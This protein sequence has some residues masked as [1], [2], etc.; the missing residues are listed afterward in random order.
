MDPATRLGRG[1][2]DPGGRAAS[3]AATAA[4]SDPQTTPRTLTRWRPR[5]GEPRPAP[6][7]PAQSVKATGIGKVPSDGAVQVR[8]PG[9]KLTGWAVAWSVTSSATA[10]TTAATIRP[11]TRSSA[12]TLTAGP[13][14]WVGSCRTDFSVEPEHPGDRRQRGAARRALADRARRRIALTSPRIPCATFR[15][16][17]GE[18]GWLELL[19]PTPDLARTGRSSCRARSGPATR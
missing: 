7:E 3:T 6:A 12:K 14:A 16:W 18:K 11:C 4:H 10:S 8:D 15:G 9:P 2:A 17:V 1:P 5:L 19:L 13:S